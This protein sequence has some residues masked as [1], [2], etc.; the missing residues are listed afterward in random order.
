MKYLMVLLFVMLCSVNSLAQDTLPDGLNDT[1]Y[2]DL[3]NGSYDVQH[4]TIDLS[5]DPDRNF[6]EGATSIKAVATQEFEAFTL[7]FSG[8]HV[9]RVFVNDAPVIFSR[10]NHKMMIIPPLA[11]KPGDN[12]NVRVNYNGVPQP[13]ADEG[14]PFIRLGWQ[15][16]S[17]GFYA[18]VSE[19][20]GSMN[21]FPSNNHPL[22]KATFT[23]RITVPQPNVVAADGILYETFANSNANT[24]DFITVAES[25][26][27][28]DLDTLF[29]GWLFSDTIP[30]LPE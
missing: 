14:V 12:L 2:P 7:D 24:S 17:D 1:L 10:A 18:S 9:T 8:L 23:Y 27:G 26:S 28:Q 25:V 22:D 20:S 29:D 4:Y 15:R 19:P 30:D 11:F 3:G 13:V 21:W 5:F 16:F 6:I